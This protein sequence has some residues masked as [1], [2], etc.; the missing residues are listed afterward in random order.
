MAVLI[1][2]RRGSASDWTTHNPTLEEGE[3]GVELDTGKF[4][5]GNGVDDWN[6]LPYSSGDDG[7]DGADGAL[8]YAGAGAPG[9]ELG[10]EGD[11]YLDSENG[12]VFKKEG[13]EWTQVLNM[14]GPAGAP[15]LQTLHVIEDATGDI[16]LDFSTHPV[17]VVH[18]GSDDVAYTLSS[19]LPFV[20]E[21]WDSAIWDFSDSSQYP[22]LQNNPLPSK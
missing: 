10:N 19:P 14:I 8:W 4:K 6:A 15:P 3:F 18:Q 12:D 13:A 11:F 21:G 9:A 22:T 20:L 7:V 16:T 17:Y 2:L 5:V 1:Q